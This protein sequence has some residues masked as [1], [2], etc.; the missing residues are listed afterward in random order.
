MDKIHAMLAVWRSLSGKEASRMA[1]RAHQPRQT[2]DIDLRAGKIVQPV[3]QL[4][5]DLTARGNG[6]ALGSLF[7]Y[8]LNLTIDRRRAGENN[9]R[10]VM[11]QRAVDYLL[12]RLQI[13]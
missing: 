8:A 2:N 12:H 6:T 10:Y 13:K 5:Q 3:F 9:A 1:A 4:F 11:R 7:Y